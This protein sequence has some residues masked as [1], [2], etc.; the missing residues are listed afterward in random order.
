MNAPIAMVG[1][2]IT[3]CNQRR[4]R[5]APYRLIGV[6]VA[7]LRPPD[8]PRSARPPGRRARTGSSR[9]YVGGSCGDLP[10]QPASCSGAFSWVSGLRHAEDEKST[11]ARHAARL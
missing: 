7:A 1:E 4:F 2:K 5:A 6:T 9:H 8:A 10:R 3:L 11:F